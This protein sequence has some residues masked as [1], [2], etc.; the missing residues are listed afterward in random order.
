MWPMQ[1]PFAACDPPAGLSTGA[2]RDWRGAQ[3]DLDSITAQIETASG[4]GRDY[5]LRSALIEQARSR[6][7]QLVM[8]H[9]GAG[10]ARE[11]LQA[12]ER[13]RISFVPGTAPRASAGDRLR[14]PEGKVVLE[15]ALIGDRL[16]AWTVRGDSVTLD[17]SVVDR[18]SLVFAI[19]R[20]GRALEAGRDARPLLER[21]HEW[22]MRPVLK[23]LP[24]GAPLVI[25]ADGEIGRVPFVALRD[26][27]TRKDLLETRTLSLAS[28]LA[29]VGGPEP[30]VGRSAPRALLVADPEFNQ[31]EH[32]T[33]DPLDGARGEMDTLRRLFY[34]GADTL[35]GRNV[36]IDAFRERARGAD[37]IHYAGHAVFDDTHPGRSFLVLAGAERLTADTITRW[38]LDGV[39]LVV[40]SACSTIRARHGR[41]GGF[42]GLSGA[43]LAAGADGVVGSLWKVSDKL[44]QPLME[45]FHRQY[46]TS[47][48]PAD[49]LRKAQ[50]KMRS[51]G[52]P[53]TVW[54]GF[55]YVGG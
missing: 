5:H 37:V 16:L 15:Y 18:D 29:D 13:G 40:L 51:E 12:L 11:A 24:A 54:A 50:L 46:R 14:G 25:V 1:A 30:A 27:R 55:R 44:A 2:G 42:A 52:H 22:L 49:A 17:Q 32:P 48:D 31:R 23:H 38:E 47:G 41:S 36:S 33:L 4:R 43:F 39:R 10:R 20:V 34:P 26:P 45:E 53:P 7:D 28:R 35:S 21:L 3:A 8:L 6:F 9:V 19:E